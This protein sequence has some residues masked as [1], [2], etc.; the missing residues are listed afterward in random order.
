MQVRA[1]FLCEADGVEARQLLDALTN[2]LGVV[3]PQWGAVFGDQP[4]QHAIGDGGGP[5]WAWTLCG[6]VF[7]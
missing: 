2:Y 3:H 5:A 7:Q 4:G 1:G 6:G